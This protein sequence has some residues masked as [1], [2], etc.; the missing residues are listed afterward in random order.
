MWHI[1]RT[2]IARRV[3]ARFY[4]LDFKKEMVVLEN[5]PWRSIDM[6]KTAA[7]AKSIGKNTD[8]TTRDLQGD[9]HG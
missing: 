6:K 8:Y 3:H 9:L 4:G 5:S 1:S 2:F 7:D